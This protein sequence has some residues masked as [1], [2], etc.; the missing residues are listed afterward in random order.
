LRLHHNPRHCRRLL[1]GRRRL[2][3]NEQL[4]WVQLLP[5]ALE[6]RLGQLHVLEEQ[7]K[8]WQLVVA[9]DV[10]VQGQQMGPQQNL[11]LLLGQLDMAEGVLSEVYQTVCCYH[12]WPEWIVQHQRHRDFRL[13]DLH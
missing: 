7:L 2:Q 9:V 6:K 1:K 12:D 10:K 11:N 8:L 4:V 3:K 5:V 13:S